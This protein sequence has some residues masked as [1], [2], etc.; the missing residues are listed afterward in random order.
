MLTEG[1]MGRL[2]RT[3]TAV[4]AVIVIVVGSGPLAHAQPRI[5]AEGQTARLLHGRI[6]G[7]TTDDRGGPLAGVVV[8]ALGATM[9][10]TVSD[11]RGYFSIDALPPGEYVV[12]AHLSGFA[13][14]VRERV[15]VGP[16]SPAVQKFQLRRLDAPLGTTGTVVP[17][18][19]RP[20]MAAGFELPGS[21]LTDQPD[22]PPADPAADHP[23]T[24]TAWRLR[25]IRRSILKDASPITTLANGDDGDGDDIDLRPG[26]A[27]W[28]AIDSTANMAASLFGDMPLSGEVNLLTSGAFAPGDLFS[29]DTVPRG[30]AYLSL[31]LPTARGDWTMRA[32]M[33]EGDLSSWNVAG[34]F[35]SRPGSTHQLDFGLTYSRQDYAGGNPSALAAV[36]DNSRNVGEVYAF[37]TWTVTP[38]LTVEYGSRYA[39]Y[40]YLQR[41]DLLSPRTSVA[42][43][44][45][46]G[47]RVVTSV[48]QRMVAPGA[49]EFLT[50]NA[51]GP[52]L[53]PERTFAPLRG[54]V[55]PMNMRV[56]RARTVSV[57]LEHEFKDDS[58]VTVQRFFQRVDDQ[59][60]TL[61]GL[62]LPDGPDSAGHYFVAS[63]GGVDAD[64]WA[65]RVS[66]TSNPRLKGSIDYSVTRARWQGAGDF[67]ASRRLPRPIGWRPETEDLHDITTS[68]E[69]DIPETATRVVVVYKV[70]T[71]YSRVDQTQPGPGLDGRFNIQLNQALPFAFAGTR[72]EVLVGVRNLFRDPTD[73]ASVYDEL[74]VVRPPKRVMGGFLVRF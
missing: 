27:L 40:D 8:S 48:A 16:A 43:E 38:R 26:S 59:L 12:Q 46:P 20:I 65:V 73:P 71:G 19:A 56:E 54:T 42:V 30:V 67:G 69:T 50:T 57:G 41:G 31:G 2:H 70:N 25:H 1:A 61:F 22:A 72:W 63:A 35:A 60:V 13:G 58:V 18:A 23:H 29:G 53:P 3:V 33:S 68:L 34:A 10:M 44:A 7:T 74:L 36:T 55:D 37:D 14:S 5:Q 52:W 11:V 45:L 17:V 15:Q 28:R 66:N 21:T 9:A 49:E 4:G 6:T 39:R 24:E 64:G 51:P 62:H 32:A 47:T